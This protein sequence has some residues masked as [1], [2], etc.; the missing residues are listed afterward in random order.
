[1]FADV[2]GGFAERGVAV[3]VAKPSLVVE[4]EVTE[5]KCGSVLWS[6]GVKFGGECFGVVEGGVRCTI[7]QAQKNWACVGVECVPGAFDSGR[8]GEVRDA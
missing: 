2:V 8:V 3:G 4:V 6:V 7:P 5:E 1:M